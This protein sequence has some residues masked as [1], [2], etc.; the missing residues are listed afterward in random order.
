MS[1]RPGGLVLRAGLELGDALVGLL[2]DRAAYALADML[3]LAWYRFAAARRRLVAANLA[4]VIAASGGQVSGKELR[5]LVRAAFVAHARYYL[6]VVRLPRHGRRDIDKML[7]LDDAAGFEA[8]ARTGGVIGVSAHFGNFEPAA[9]W[10]A[11]HGLRWLAPIERIEPPELFAYLRSR[12]GA[13]SVGGEMVPPPA[14]R[15]VLSALRHGEVV[16]IAADRDVLGSGR[17]VSFFGHPARVPDGPA[18]LA[19][20]TGAPVVVGTLRRT[21][22]NRFAAR[23]DLVAWTPTGNRG[24]DVAALTQ[25]IT[26]VLA[27]HIAR[28]PEQWWGAFQPIWADLRPGQLPDLLA[29]GGRS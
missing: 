13:G 1:L 17:E 5:R 20:L 12:R 3:G 19:V 9:I 6:E 8:L 29:D 27:D 4:R 23:T 22:P 18:T 11:S 21:A 7:V 25:R 28:A 16:G 15:R 14:G 26:D 10:L 2:P 24:S